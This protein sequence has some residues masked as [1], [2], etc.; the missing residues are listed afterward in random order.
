VHHG[1]QHVEIGARRDLDQEVA[2]DELAATLQPA[3]ADAAAGVLDDG[4]LL[5]RDP[6]QSRVLLEEPR[7]SV[8]APA[9][10][11]AT[12]PVAG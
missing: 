7:T 6:P 9:P 8:P 5:E 4:R 2:R 10:M 11:S 1:L 3:L 12:T